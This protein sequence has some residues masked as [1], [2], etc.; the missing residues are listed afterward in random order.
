MVF[1]FDDIMGEMIY[2]M[3]CWCFFLEGRVFW[4]ISKLMRVK[5]LKFLRSG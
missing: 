1:K 4:E 3:V 5:F 2:E